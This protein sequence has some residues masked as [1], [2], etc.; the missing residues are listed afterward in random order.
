MTRERFIDALYKIKTAI[1][2]TLFDFKLPYLH[3]GIMQEEEPLLDMDNVSGC[4]NIEKLT[5]L[6][7]ENYRNS[8]TLIN[9]VFHELV[10]YYCARNGIKDCEQHTYHNERFKEAVK[11]QIGELPF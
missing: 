4:I 10:H 2:R 7:N 5:I 9:T 3:I 1:N 6:V 11:E 8:D